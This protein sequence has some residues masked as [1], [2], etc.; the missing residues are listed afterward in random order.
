MNQNQNLIQFTIK[1]KSIKSQIKIKKTLG[2][3]SRKNYK[4]TTNCYYNKIGNQIVKLKPDN[5][6]FLKITIEMQRSR[7]Y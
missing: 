3:L 2:E 7:I 1:I 4:A 6:D 5:F